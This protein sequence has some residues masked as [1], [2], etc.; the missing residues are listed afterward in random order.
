MSLPAF[1]GAACELNGG[2]SAAPELIPSKE[3]FLA[4]DF[5]AGGKSVFVGD[6]NH[7]IVDLGVKHFRHE[8]GAD[9]LN[10]VRAGLALREHG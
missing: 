9:P 10:G 6:V 3:A 2:K 4:R 5:P 7:L 8:P 1:S